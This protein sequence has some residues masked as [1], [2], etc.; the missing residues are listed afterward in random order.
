MI[1]GLESLD[2]ALEKLQAVSD[3]ESTHVPIEQ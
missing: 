2:S 1:R 3:G